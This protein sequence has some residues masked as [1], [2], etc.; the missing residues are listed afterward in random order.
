MHRWKSCILGF[1]SRLAITNL[2]WSFLNIEICQRDATIKQFHIDPVFKVA[3]LCR[4][5]TQTNC[6]VH[7]EVRI[8][9]SSLC[10]LLLSDA[11]TRC[12]DQ[13]SKCAAFMTR[14]LYPARRDTICVDAKP[15]RAKQL[16]EDAT[17]VRKEPNSNTTIFPRKTAIKQS[18][19]KEWMESYKNVQ[20][21]C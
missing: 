1:G 7:V 13:C 8:S 9:A 18:P 21:N 4:L 5:R 14:C 10:H 20:L 3:P 16:L 2:S 17:V 15:C 11:C 12:P 6:Y 19:T